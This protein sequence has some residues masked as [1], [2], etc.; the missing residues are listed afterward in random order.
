MTRQEKIK[1]FEMK[2]DGYSLSEI[3]DELGYTKQWISSMFQWVM[4]EKRNKFNVVY[5]EIQKFMINK[6]YT[7]TM[8]AEQ[9]CYTVSTVSLY[10]RGKQKPSDAFVKA[11]EQLTHIDR[12]KLFRREDNV[13][14]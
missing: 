14:M 11:M 7:F 3:A 9:I 6:Q 2:M 4:E 10:L 13:Q 12:E 5:P 1:A 8:I